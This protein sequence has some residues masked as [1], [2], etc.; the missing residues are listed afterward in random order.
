MMMA[1]QDEVMEW[2]RS[3]PEEIVKEAARRDF[4]TFARWMKPDL[5]VTPFHKTLYRILGLFADGKLKKVMLSTPPQHGKSEACSRLLPAY[6][7]GRNPD[8]KI[9]VESYSTTLARG[10]NRDV[11]RMIDDPKYSC[12][13]PNTYLSK[14]GSFSMERSYIRTNDMF[15]VPLHSGFLKTVG[16]GSALTGTTLTV[17]ISDDLYANSIEGN[18]PNIRENTWLWYVNVVRSRLSNHSRSLILYTRWH[19]DDV[20]GMIESN[21]N[22]IYPEKWSDLDNIP[23]GAWVKFNF[24]AIKTS[25]PTEIDPRLPGE[26]LWPERHSLEDLLQ[27][28]SLDKVQFDLLYQG[29]VVTAA[30]LLYHEFNT[31]KDGHMNDFGVYNGTFAQIDPADKGT[32]YLTMVIYDIFDD[33]MRPD[34]DHKPYRYFLIREVYMSQ[35]SIEFT[36]VEVPLV[37]AKYAGVQDVRI[38]ANSAGHA[39]AVMI[40]DKIQAGITEFNQSLNKEAKVL[41]YSGDVN[42]RCVMPFGWENT[43]KVAYA[44]LSGFRREFKSNA[45]DDLP[46]TL[47][48]IIRT[49]VYAAR[50]YGLTV[51]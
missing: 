14:G 10:F 48:E 15:E 21:E 16:R 34:Q 49:H 24:P 33:P 47:S 27:R 26:A 50:S 44:Q 42:N 23:D 36:S 46:D 28:R 35:K 6:L 29:N 1:K 7:L 2:L 22:V 12:L 39:F 32:D 51:S 18:S 45:H 20:M 41:T 17:S 3:H 4:L 38:E 25:Q 9:A 31:W 8:E 43:C 5:A 19:K 40:R 37:I 30:G 11:Q 13:F